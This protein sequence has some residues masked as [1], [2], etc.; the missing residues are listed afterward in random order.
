MKKTKGQWLLDN[1]D[2]MIL[3]KILRWTARIW[4]LLAFTLAMVVAFSP[5]PNAVNPITTR[6]S[7]MLSLWLVAIL[8]LLLA[9][10]FERLGALITIIIMPV[11]ELLYFLIYREWTINFLLIW[12]LVIPPAVIYLIAWS[13]DRKDNNEA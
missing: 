12:A 11:R 7:F 4:S 1:P 8:G 6:E 13:R 3:L 5:D 9:W 2:S 10:R